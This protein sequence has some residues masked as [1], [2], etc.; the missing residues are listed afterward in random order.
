[1]DKTQAKTPKSVPAKMAMTVRISDSQVLLPF[2]IK[3]VLKAAMAAVLVAVVMVVATAVTTLN[4]SGVHDIID[5]AKHTKFHMLM[6][7]EFNFRRLPHSLS[8]L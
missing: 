7:F 4:R 6:A 2:Q 8:F 5:K 1:M 3:T